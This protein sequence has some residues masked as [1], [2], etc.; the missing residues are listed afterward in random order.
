MSISLAILAVPSIFSGFFFKDFFLGFGSFS[1][2]DFVLLLPQNSHFFESDYML[3]VWRVAPVVTSFTLGF[4]FAF[5]F[6]FM[7]RFSSSLL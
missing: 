1:F 5:G 6:D 3:A 7:Y 4:L 2:A